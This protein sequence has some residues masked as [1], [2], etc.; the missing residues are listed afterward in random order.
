MTL[1]TICVLHA[2]VL[3]IPIGN[4][5]MRNRPPFKLRRFSVLH[6]AVLFSLSLYMCIECIRQSHRNFGWGHKFQLWCNPNDGGRSPSTGFSDSGRA[7]ANVLWIHYVSKVESSSLESCLFMQC[8]LQQRAATSP[9]M[10]LS[11]LGSISC[12]CGGTVQH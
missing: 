10:P 6:N 3:C 5:L 9:C 11:M 2:D 1:S 7:L 4:A 8:A 12:N